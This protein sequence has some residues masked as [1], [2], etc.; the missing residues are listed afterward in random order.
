MSGARTRAWALLGA[1]IGALALLGLWRTTLGAERTIAAESARTAA[2]GVAGYL[3][4]VV[5]VD[6][7][8][9][10]DGSRLLSAAALVATSGFWQ[11]GLQVASGATPLL[12]DSGGPS[13]PDD[14]AAARLRTGTASALGVRPNGGRE[15]FVPF[16]DRDLWGVVGWVAVW[17]AVPSRGVPWPLL[18]LTLVTV[19][20]LARTARAGMKGDRRR[21]AVLLAG[22]AM[23]LLALAAWRDIAGAARA[24]TA[25]SLSRARRLSE[26]ASVSRPRGVVELSRI[27]PGMVVA[28]TD[29]VEADR[30]VHRR[31]VD[32]AEEASIS[33][34]INGVRPFRLTMVPFGTRLSGTWAALAGWVLLLFAGAAFGSWAAVASRERRRF[35]E[36][37]TAWGFLAPAGVHLAIFSFGPLLFA[38]WLSFHRWGLMDAAHPWVGFKNFATLFGDPG[39]WHSLG[40]TALYGLYLPVTLALALGAALLLNRSGFRV[41]LLRTLLFIPFVASVV[42]VALV[43][44]WIYQPEAGLLNAGLELLGL[45]GPDWLGSPR[46]A[47][48]ALMLIAVWVHLGYQMVILLA[49]LQGIPEIYHDAARADGAS[50][51]QR[52]R[53][54]TL[55][56]LRP[57]ILF[58][59]VTGTIASF[60]VFTVVS[61]LTAGGPLHSTDVVVYRIYQEGWEFLRFGTAS[62]MS[63]LLALLL[64]ALAWLE[65]RW[66]GRRIELV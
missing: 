53:Y 66:L 32:G 18:A 59:L 29:S 6:R 56:L 19:W 22:G 46:T 57:T 13:L 58:V 23:A 8:G 31:T 36:I 7:T 44:Q 17:D 42:A 28:L 15:V 51:W 49:G 34:V 39:F 20:M 35:R 48:L 54:V 30:A 62:A 5:P 11:A 2:E 37:L 26:V 60:Q 10:Y 40:V 14:A 61:V 24:A 9:E 50:R 4:L 21:R 3:S 55:P 41:R 12:A 1:S 45:H 38:L 52:F 64:G 43:W 16:F 33:G 63:V 47:L 27:T 65:F 25:L